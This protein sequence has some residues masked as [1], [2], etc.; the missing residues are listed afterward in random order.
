MSSLPNWLECASPRNLINSSYDARLQKLSLQSFKDCEERACRVLLAETIR[1]LSQM[2]RF[3][4]NLRRMKW[5]FNAEISNKIV[6][7]EDEFVILPN[8]CKVFVVIAYIELERTII[9]R[10][11]SWVRVPR[12]ILLDSLN[13]DF[14]AFHVSHSERSGL[15]QVRSLHTEN[16]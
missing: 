12:R 16:S 9:Y 1:K 8:K 2:L 4:N 3:V 6:L 15:Q 11:G 14:F 10:K 7:R 5:K 13:R